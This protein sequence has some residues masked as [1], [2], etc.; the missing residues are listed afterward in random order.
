LSFE[1]MRLLRCSKNN[2]NFQE[3]I[4]H[5]PSLSPRRHHLSYMLLAK[6]DLYIKIIALNGINIFIAL[7]E[8]VFRM[9]RFKTM[10]IYI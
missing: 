9:T 8:V 3:Q 4:N 10:N 5:V 6:D 2:I 1:V 7:D